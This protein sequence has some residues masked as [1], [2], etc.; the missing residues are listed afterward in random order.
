MERKAHLCTVPPPSCFGPTLP[1]HVC[2]VGDSTFGRTPLSDY[3]VHSPIFYIRS[4]RAQ[5]TT[6]RASAHQHTREAP[7]RPRL[8]LTARHEP[9]GRVCG[10]GASTGPPWGREPHG[11]TRSR[12]GR[13]ERGGIITPVPPMAL[14]TLPIKATARGAK[15]APLHS[16]AALVFWSRE[17]R[18][19]TCTT[20]PNQLG[21]PPLKSCLT[22]A[23][24]LC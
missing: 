11:R 1:S 23:M 9:C 7:A 2:C 17:E 14:G 24:T 19:A 5:R 12:P 3:C 16:A 15:G 8:G 10:L 21:P 18:G 13:T 20:W 22:A 4:A 6:M